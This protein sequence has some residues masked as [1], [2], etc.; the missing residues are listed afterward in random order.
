M[1]RSVDSDPNTLGYRSQVQKPTTA[2]NS[3]EIADLQWFSHCQCEHYLTPT[4]Q[5]SSVPGPSVRRL[6]QNHFSI[7]VYVLCFQ[8][9]CIL[10]VFFR[11]VFWIFFYAAIWHDRDFEVVL[12]STCILPIT[13]TEK[14]MSCFDW[15]HKQW[16]YE[17][18]SS[19]CMCYA[20]K[21]WHL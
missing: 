13:L 8:Y 2:T 1:K 5:N 17:I 19:Y 6:S 20:L 16:G 9:K 10:M 15:V 14:I 18:F 3:T 12:C 21:K 4:Y 11:S 7:S